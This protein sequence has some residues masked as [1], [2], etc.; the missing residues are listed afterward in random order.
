MTHPLRLGN[1][2]QLVLKRRGLARRTQTLFQEL[3]RDEQLQRSFIASPAE[4]IGHELLGESY[5]PEQA[6]AVNQF[7]FSVLASDG[8][9]RWSAE[10]DAAHA[11]QSITPEQHLHDLA[12]AFMRH[13]DASIMKG[14]MQMAETGVNITGLTQAALFVKQESVA[15][16]TWFVYKVSGVNLDDEQPVLP[17]ALVQKIAQQLLRRAQELKRN[18]QL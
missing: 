5:T 10:Y 7:L 17:A 8:L 13:G 6:T 3:D 9:R 4:V 11:G 14:L 2:Q 18:G 1:E 16:G 12:E 15:I